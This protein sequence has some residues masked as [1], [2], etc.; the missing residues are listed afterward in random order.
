MVG[1]SFLDEYACG[2]I[3][4]YECHSCWNPTEV[5]LTLIL[6]CGYQGINALMGCDDFAI[7]LDCINF[8]AVQ[9]MGDS[10][11]RK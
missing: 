10:I 5:P 8:A 2:L 9:G 7:T 4:F 6:E 1:K 3:L 11:R